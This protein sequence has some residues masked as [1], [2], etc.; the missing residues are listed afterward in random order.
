MTKIIKIEKVHPR[1]WLPA[2][3]LYHSSSMVM[4]VPW[5]PSLVLDMFKEEAETRRAVAL[6][7]FCQGGTEMID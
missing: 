2:L 3:R 5:R 6:Q 4:T 7:F 1:C